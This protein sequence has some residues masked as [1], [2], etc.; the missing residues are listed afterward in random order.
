MI[1]RMILDRDASEVGDDA[2]AR[3]V[4]ASLAYTGSIE[5]SIRMFSVR[6]PAA[7]RSRLLGLRAGRAQRDC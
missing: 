7:R 6:C 3:T 5:H 1:F 2:L 4:G